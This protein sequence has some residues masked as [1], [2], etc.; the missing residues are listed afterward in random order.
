MVSI[1]IIISSNRFSSLPSETIT[2]IETNK[3]PTIFVKQNLSP[4]YHHHPYIK[5]I[6]TKTTGSS[7]GRNIGIKYAMKNKAKILA[8]T[9]D[10]CIITN[11]WIK[12]I[13]SQLN[14]NIDVLFG[15]TLPYQP[16]LHPQQFSVCTFS[17][18]NTSQP[19]TK[20]CRHWQKIGFSNNMAVKSKILKR[21]GFFSPLFG[22]G[23]KI[24]TCEDGE[25]IL[26]IISYQIPIYYNSQ[27]LCYHNKW[28]T[29]EQLTKQNFD[30]TKGTVGVYGFYALK[31]NLFCVSVVTNEFIEELKNF[32]F[33]NIFFLLKTLLISFYYSLIMK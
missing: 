23:T 11:S 19:I 21:V 25:L 13:K 2:V 24:P 8:F 6:L 32:H 28:L 30:Y 29:L 22:P 1:Y 17:K 12:I 10:D 31:G 3:I 7:I 33:L 5:E 14:K 20:F 27:M 18:K 26:R 15:R 9:D 4:T 16:Q